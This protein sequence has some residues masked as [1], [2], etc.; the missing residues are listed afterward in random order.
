[1]SSA[2]GRGPHVPGNQ[3]RDAQ[4]YGA[5]CAILALLAF[6]A[7]ASVVVAFVWFINTDAP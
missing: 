6:L 3:S 2:K 7:V 5:S 1:M 4:E